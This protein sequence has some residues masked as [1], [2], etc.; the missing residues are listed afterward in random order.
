[1]TPG[2]LPNRIGRFEFLLWCGAPIVVGAIALATWAV[3]I[4]VGDVDNPLPSLKGPFAGLMLVISM[5]ILRAA[6][7]R[8]H[9]LGWPGWSILL[10]FI[11]LV[12]VIAFLFLLLAPGKKPPNQYGEPQ[13]CLRWL[14]KAAL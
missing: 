14:R 13:V 4:G 1:M 9:D 5:L 10:I 11:P 6:V 2:M 7:S 8:F 3:I 12:D